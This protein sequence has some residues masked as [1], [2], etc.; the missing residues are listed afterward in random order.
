MHGG[1]STAGYRTICD[2]WDDTVASSPIRLV[3]DRSV[4]EIEKVIICCRCLFTIKQP[5]KDAWRSLPEHF[6]ISVPAG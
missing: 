4:S 5:V 2:E 1:L 3:V 6:G